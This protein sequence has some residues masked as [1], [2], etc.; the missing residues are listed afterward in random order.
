[1]PAASRPP[2]ASRSA[3]PAAAR[4]LAAL[5]LLVGLSLVVT[6]PSGYN[7]DSLYVYAQAKDLLAFGSLRG[8]TFSAIPFTVPDLI[9]AAPI[10][11]IVPGPR[12]YYVVAAPLQMVLLGAALSWWLARTQQRP[13][14]RTLLSFAV[15]AALIV[16]L[17]GAAFYPSGYFAAQPLFIL[18]YHGFAAICATLLTVVACEDDFRLLRQHWAATLIAVA[19]L[20]ASDFYFAAYFGAILTAALLLSRS[21]ALLRLVLAVG[22]VSVAVFA[23]SYWLNP[24][25]GLHIRESNAIVAELRPAHAAARLAALMIVPTALVLALRFRGALSR[26]SLILYMA[27]LLIAAALA[28]A[29]LIKDWSGFRYL[30]ILLPVSLVLMLDLVNA[31]PPRRQAVLLAIAAAGLGAAL[32]LVGLKPS[33]PL[34]S[35]RDEIACIDAADRPGSTIVATY[36]PA[37]LIF[38]GTGRRHN[39]IQVNA[40][41]QPWDWISNRRWRSL[42]PEGRTTFVV[43]E[44][45]S[46]QTLAHLT[47]DT[48]ARAICGGK[49]LQ[50][51]RPPA[52]LGIL[53]G[54]APGE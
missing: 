5:G 17:I 30:T 21:R 27:L 48:D 54:T 32:L 11:A 37:K 3:L 15:A 29:G 41:L 40:D 2:R 14:D 10:A 24:S 19:V 49:L 6:L 9:A 46:M 52:E 12:A 36:W 53:K 28:A 39:L 1:M 8:W 22:G 20:T 44:H 25:L 38:E 47:N 45:L 7:S 31:M 34:S 42:H 33:S 35:Y 4:V 51:D 16:L 50:I 23:L 43:T 13:L 26:R 18:N